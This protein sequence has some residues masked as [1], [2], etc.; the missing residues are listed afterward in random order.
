MNNTK[1]VIGGG[2][3]G[4]SLAYKLLQAGIDDVVIIEKERELGGL[5]RTFEFD[6]FV[7]DLGPHRFYTDDQ[8]VFDFIMDILGKDYVKVARASALHI[9][10]KYYHWPFELR[11]AV[12]LPPGFAFFSFL[13]LLFK[14][15]R[16]EVTFADFVLNRYGK[17][18]LY[19]FFDPYYT[20]AL[21]VP[22]SEIHRDYASAGV[23]RAVIDKRIKV[24]NLFS[25]IK[26]AFKK[27]L[28]THFICP[29]GGIRTFINRIEQR[30]KQLGGRVICNAQVTKVHMTDH[31]ITKLEVG[32]HVFD[33]DE[34]FWSAPIP[35]I[36]ELLNIEDVPKLNYLSTIFYF[37]AIDRPPLIDHQWIY[38]AGAK[39][40]FSRGSITTLFNEG[41]APPGKHGICIELPMLP[42]D[43]LL[44]D[45]LKKD[46]AIR[47][48][49]MKAGLIESYDDIRAGYVQAVHNTY[50]IYSLQ[51]REDLDNIFARIR[52]VCHN[53]HMFGRCGYFW[54]NNMDH[55]I[56]MSLDIA[57]AV[58]SGTSVED[59][60]RDFSKG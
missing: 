1:I 46:A 35:G 20:K 32:N 48:H 54:Y 26:S 10:N 27:K 19:K 36:L 41:Y 51:Y 30:I 13:D 42:G 56:R 3:A 49:M 59:F 24:D 28:K 57:A 21:K 58:S 53:V 40:L 23:D 33:V 60:E 25:L 29:D 47:E 55:S 4:V 12:K 22:C 2:V 14:K 6:G 45:P 37:Y 31:K 50:P 34:L 15:G 18:L 38:Y 16:P 11:D 39:T 9:F 44:D 17:T 8:E 43:P 5:A 52:S 7:F